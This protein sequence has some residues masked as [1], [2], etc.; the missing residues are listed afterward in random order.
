MVK[1]KRLII[2]LLLIGTV[3]FVEGSVFSQDSLDKKRWLSPLKS[4]QILTGIEYGVLP[5]LISNDI[6]QDNFISEGQLGLEIYQLPFNVS[7]RYSSKGTLSGINNHFTVDFDAEK[8]IQSQKNKIEQKKNERLKKIDSLE[9][10]LQELERKSDYLD[11]YKDQTVEVPSQDID[12]QKPNLPQ[13]E[14][15]DI[16]KML[17]DSIPIEEIKRLIYLKSQKLDDLKKNG[18]KRTDKFKDS[19]D[20]EKLKVNELITSTE[21]LLDKYKSLP[22]LQEPNV[23]EHRSRFDHKEK[24]ETKTK[25]IKHKITSIASG[26]KK[27]GVGLTNPY[28]SEFLVSRTPLRGINMEYNKKKIYVAFAHGKTVNNLFLTNNV[29]QNNLNLVQNSFNFFEFNNV[30]NGRRITALKAGYG[31]KNESHIYF[32]FLNGL[33]KVSYQD[34]SLNTFNESNFVLEID[35]RI[36]LKKHEFNLVSG[37]SAIKTIGIADSANTSLLRNLSDF[38]F[39]SNALMGSYEYKLK[40]TE[41]F[42]GVRLIDPFFRSLGVGFLRSDNLRFEVK[43]KR[44]LNKKIELGGFFRKERDNLIG[45]YAFEN[46]IQSY[47]VDINY[48]L[49][50]RWMLRMDVRPLNINTIE[51]NSLIDTNNI[52]NQNLIV[53][54]ISSYNRRIK[55]TYISGTA[56]F[57]H[58]QLLVNNNIN[59]YQNTNLSL[60]IQKKQVLSYDFIFNNL[61]ST[62]EETSPFNNL[63]QVATTLTKSKYSLQG[64]IK[65]GFGMTRPGDFGY[66]LNLTGFVTK[67]I[68]L[69]IRAEK[70]V[71]GDFYSNIFQQELD[72]FPFYF[73]GNILIKW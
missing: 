15:I 28:F 50:K 67:H 9:L 35:A 27:F 44:S 21:A 48:K 52:S 10:K 58:Y 69:N 73:A 62:D 51:S 19:I 39:R 18:L 47:G 16:S 24:I 63:L 37:K 12:I 72:E 2:I 25:S 54:L 70:V 56:L 26:I 45:I 30:Q 38:N 68:G 57:S 46:I 23:D 34:S 6:P 31:N 29:L 59:V 33:G 7:Y 60:N 61:R 40:K 22:E 65:Y 13:T 14:M 3:F 36:K 66:G 11:K 5:F 4:G 53:N 8:F 71:L 20:S 42:A 17:E 41:L 55:E 64:S 43:M 32:G 49:S 1:N